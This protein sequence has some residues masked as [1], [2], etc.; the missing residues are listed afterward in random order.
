MSRVGFRQPTVWR[1]LWSIIG[2][3]VLCGMLIGIAMFIYELT[4]PSVPP[5]PTG[6]YVRLFF[7]DITLW[8]PIMLITAWPFTVPAILVL[9]ALV[10]S[11]RR[12]SRG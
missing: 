9:G 5:T 6:D 2:V 11:L 12:T 8:G 10:A 4:L 1:L 7:L 3:A